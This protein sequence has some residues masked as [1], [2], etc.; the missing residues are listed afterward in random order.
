MKN[1]FLILSFLS[2]N[3]LFSQERQLNIEIDTLLKTQCK[4][5]EPGL[6]VG[7]V[8]DGKIIY[9]NQHGLANLE[10]QIPINDST[11]FGIASITKQFTSA[12]IAV[13]EKRGLLNANDAVR[14][15]I[16]QLPYFG[17]TIRIK[18]LLNHTSGL[19]N[20][21][22]LL[23]LKGFDLRHQGYTNKMIEALTFIQKGVNNK[24]GEKMLYSNT[25]YVLLAL[26]IKNVSGL[27]I[28]DFSEKELFIPLK[29]TNTFFKR[30]IEQIIKNRAYSYYNENGIFKQPKS[31][32]LCVGAGGIGSTI[33]DMAKWSAIFLNED[34][35]FSYIKSFLSRLDTLNNGSLMTSARGVF[36]SR[37]KGIETIHHGGRD[38]GM[39][40]QFICI[41]EL[42][43][44]VTIFTNSEHINADQLSY[45]IIDLFIKDK[46]QSITKNT[47]PY[48]HKQKELNSFLGDYQELNSDL[49]LKI[50]LVNDSLSAQ[51]SFAKSP[52][53]LVPKVKNKFQRLNDR[54]V[55]YIFDP[56]SSDEADLLVDFGGATFYF[57][58]VNLAREKEI[59]T[60]EYL[61][62]FYSQELDV[63]YTITAKNNTLILNYPNNEDIA[64]TIGQTDEFG[65]GRRTKYSFI[66]NK[67][68]N[69]N[70]FKLASE[71][72]VKDILFI[73]N[74]Y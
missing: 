73:K 28:A 10:Y 46:E 48:Q 14:K 35:K 57:E 50:A 63:S 58:K 2:F 31:L 3:Y 55:S 18:H 69:I 9:H 52:I 22:V 11:I 67:N 8:K 39:R 17:D 70:A 47:K 66:R 13:L 65:S 33:K 51:S 34:S 19:R 23:D 6:S 20:H 5:Y 74:K 40:S 32:T 21:N 4:N 43:L 1:L 7:V 30:D 41:P 44:S 16:T 64:L 45:Q 56:A 61:G 60:K 15:Y 71:G 24:P 68:G 49:L 62:E 42:S 26:I 38:L 54:S 12:C 53:T 59:N 27:N 37:Y 72:T 29:M 36:V 25:N